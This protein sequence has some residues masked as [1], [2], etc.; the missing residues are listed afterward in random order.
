MSKK[1][2]TVLAIV[3]P[4]C[5]NKSSVGIEL[6]KKYPFEIISADSRLV[7]KEMDIGTSKPT[8]EERKTIPHY[9]IDLV[10]PNEEYSVALYKREAEK[11]IENVFK[12]GK[13][14]L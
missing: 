5:T 13:I 2:A 1:G 4:T 6:A 7:Y 11:N 14:P 3:G 12:K 10:F 8:A 9:M